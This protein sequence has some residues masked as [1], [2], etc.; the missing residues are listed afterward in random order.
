MSKTPSHPTPSES[1]QPNE[2]VLVA[3]TPPGGLGQMQV[4]LESFVAFN[5]W[6]TRELTQL[7]DRFVGFQTSRSTSRRRNERP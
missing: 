7:E 5:I 3:L 4:E 6:M 1:S 2:R